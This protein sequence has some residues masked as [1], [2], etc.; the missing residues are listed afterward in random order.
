MP[1]QLIDETIESIHE[2]LPKL[3][4][5]AEK[6]S[7]DIQYNRNNWLDALLMFLDGMDW[8]IQA[9]QGIR[10]IND[11][12]LTEWDGETMNSL[13]V[14]MNQAME[15]SDFV[16]M[17]DLLQHEMKPLLSTFQANLEKVSH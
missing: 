4:A 10:K 6:I 15:Q 9:V 2:Y 14:Q 13:L 16:S 1:Q 3:S 11:Q 17:S 12:L 5:A 8:L 7:S